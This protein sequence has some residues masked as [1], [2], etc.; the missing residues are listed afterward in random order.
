MNCPDHESLS[1]FV[2][3]E[4]DPPATAF[5]ER[6][7]EDCAA[8]REFVAEMRWLDTHGRTSL[9]A[10]RTTGWKRAVIPMLTQR[11]R[12]THPLALA[13]TA[14]VLASLSVT[15]WVVTNRPKEA[16]L[17][18]RT[19]EHAKSFRETEQVTATEARLPANGVER[20]AP[21]DEAFERWAEPYRR[22][23]IPLIPLEDVA[24][25]KPAVVRP[26]MP[27]AGRSNPRS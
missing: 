6:H 14:V 7:L 11:S 23:R 9:Q 20:L 26:I 13:A 19:S 27:E 1:A 3:G 5:I 10:V 18:G 16:D 21:S 25:Y 17:L 15:V 12:M 4:L 8:C 24:N 22:L 2:D